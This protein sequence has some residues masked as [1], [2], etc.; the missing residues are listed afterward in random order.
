MFESAVVYAVYINWLNNCLNRLIK[1]TFTLD[2]S[3]PMHKF[4]QI[5]DHLSKIKELS[6][7][8]CFGLE[9]PVKSD[10]FPK[11]KLLK[12]PKVKRKY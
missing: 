3:F 4:T 8:T 11:L 1:L 12:S 9:N 5:A 6:W 2:F 10:P 7:I